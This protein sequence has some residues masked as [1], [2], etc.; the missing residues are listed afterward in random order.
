M[1]H[2]IGHQKTELV[3]R[4]N[5]IEGQISGIKRMVENEKSYADILIQLNSSRSAIQKI[6]QILLE[7]Q[8][9][10]SLMLVNEGENL[11]T[12]M[13]VLRQTIIQYNKMNWDSA[14][15]QLSQITIKITRI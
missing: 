6:S 2:K 15:C 10:H 9:E 8:A 5:K 13:T 3:K 14:L 1:S 4:L 11:E 7:A 12:Q